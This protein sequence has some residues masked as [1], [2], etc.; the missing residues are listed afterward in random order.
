LTNFGWNNPDR[1]FGLKFR[2]FAR[3]RELFQGVINHPWFNPTDWDFF[4]PVSPSFSS[5]AHR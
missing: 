2:R 1:A 5:C 4:V 3:E